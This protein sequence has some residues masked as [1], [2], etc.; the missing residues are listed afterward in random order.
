MASYLRKMI[1]AKTQYK[2]YN[3]KFLAIVEVFKTWKHVQKSYKHK[4]IIL[5]DYNNFCHFMDTKILSSC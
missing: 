3:S 4:V 2:T 1:P 5:I